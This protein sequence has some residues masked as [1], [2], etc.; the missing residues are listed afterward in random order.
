MKIRAL[1][2]FLILSVLPIVSSGQVQCPGCTKP[3]SITTVRQTSTYT[4]ATVTMSDTGLS[5]NVFAGKKYRF[6]IVLMWKESTAADGA[7]LDFESSTSTA[8]T[9][10]VNCVLTNAVGSNVAHVASTVS[11]LNT[12]M[13]IG[14]FTNT[15]DH[16]E[17]CA[18]GYEP[19]T[20]GTFTLRAAQST[21]STGTL[22]IYPTSSW[23]TIEEVQ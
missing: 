12:D 23:M 11:N 3:N 21:H 15:L 20:S 13:V 9:F 22:T 4:N 5:V 7:R 19:A 10:L 14:A 6:H 2:L 18:G 16:M 17:T 1:I 8:T